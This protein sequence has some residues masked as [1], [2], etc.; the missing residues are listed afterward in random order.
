MNRP[1]LAG[2]RIIDSTTVLAAPYSMALLG[3]MGADVIKVEAHTRAV[4]SEGM[5][6]RNEVSDQSWNDGG[7]FNVPNRSKRGITLDLKQPEGMEV[8]RKLI[9]TADIFVENNRPGANARLGIDYDSL[10]QIKPDLIV[11][12]NSGFGQDGPWKFYG[13]IGRMLEPTTGLASLTGYSGGAPQR[14][15]SAYVDLQ[16]TYAMVFLLMSALIH[17]ERTGRGQYLDLSMYQVGVSMVGDAVLEYIANGDQGERRGDRDRYLAP[18]NAYPCRGE[19]RWV[20]L[21]VRDDAEWQTLCRLMEMPDIAG[22][23]R[24][25]DGL[26]RL[27][28]QDEI[29]PLI[30]DWT[31][32]HSADEV[33]QLL[34]AHGIPAGRANDGRDLLLD[35]QLRARGFFEPVTH[36]PA[37]RLGT[38]V[39]QGQPYRFS[40]GGVG[41]R[42]PAPMLG[43]HN[44]E[45]L[46]EL[47][48]DDEQIAELERKQVIGRAPIGEGARREGRQVPLDVQLERGLIRA[49]DPNFEEVLAEAYF[50]AGAGPGGKSDPKPD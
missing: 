19:D 15:G 28:H 27:E 18:Q 6:Y 35:P 16:V 30:A 7:F 48:Y 17:R 37:V 22:D 44:W 43:E 12:S 40:A 25:A 8:L 26:G 29:D 31:R 9:A 46:R 2:V 49:I 13:G 45:V 10:R 5:L 21:T 42:R 33:M 34:Q 41:I 24:F 32:R 47:G 3:D 4:R 39:Y 36:P 1:P 23:P 38:R 11:L 14:V 20:V 50:P